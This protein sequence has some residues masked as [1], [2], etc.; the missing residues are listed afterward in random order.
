M[1]THSQ[2][3]AQTDLFDIGQIG[4][5]G[6]IEDSTTSTAVAVSTGGKAF[7]RQPIARA[8]DAYVEESVEAVIE[9]MIRDGLLE[10]GRGGLIRLTY[11]GWRMLERVEAEER[12]ARNKTET[13]P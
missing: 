13:R 10:V 6:R 11:K 8:V 9:Q 7:E 4:P 12:T 3:Q 2:T 5:I 1:E